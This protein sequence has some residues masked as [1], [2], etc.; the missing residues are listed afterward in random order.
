M[1]QMRRMYAAVLAAATLASIPVWG[2]DH[3]TK[4]T[5]GPYQ[6]YTDAGTRPG[7]ETL[8]RFEEFRHAVSEVLGENDLQTQLPVRILLFRN[9]EGW[10]TPEPV[11]EGRA[12][13]NIVLSENDVAKGAGT[14][15]IFSALTKL[16]LESN[17]A[18][19][20][21]QFERGLAE[22]FSTFSIKDIH[23]TVGAAP[24]NAD[25]DWARIHL[26]VTDLD[27]FG[28]LRVLLYNLRKGAAEE[29]AYLNAFGKSQAEVEALVKRRFEQHDTQT[30]SISSQPMAERDFPEREV[31]DSDARLARADLLVGEKSAAEYEKLIKDGVH[32]ADAEEGL[33]LIALHEGHSAE[34][35]VHFADA[36]RDGSSSPRAYIEYAKLETDNGKASAALLKAAGINP[37]L[38]EPFALL[39]ERDTDPEKRLAHW[40]LATERSPRNTTYWQHLAD[41]Y[42]ADH[43]Y[44]GAAKAFTSGEQSATTAAD[45]TRM[46]DARL[47]IEQQRLDYEEAERRRKAEEEAREIARLKGEART[48]VHALEKKYSDGTPGDEL[49][50]VPWWDDPKT[51]ATAVGTLTRVECLAGTQA[52]LTIVTDDKKMLKLL[53]IDPTKLS[54]GGAGELTFRCGVQKARRVSVGYTP[55]SNSKFATSG[56]AAVI[57]FQ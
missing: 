2:A 44:D 18:R 14:P 21:P 19:M 4:F 27:Y 37:K 38:D 10:T 33:G 47:A 15:A 36:V 22:F 40:K 54:I 51:P 42:L 41:A 3:W 24:A 48:E 39:A 25:L 28:K 23:I 31:S 35:K 13:Y 5:A 26:F 55:K 49:K 12:S 52:R 56:E 57:E 6:I 30:T 50:A 16:L 8:V 1:G 43:N 9:A 7:R 11:S 20:P 46:H 17:T 53:V 34:A 29:P 32:T 45:R